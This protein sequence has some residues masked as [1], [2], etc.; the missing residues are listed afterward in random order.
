MYVVDR[1]QMVTKFVVMCY[2][3]SAAIPLLNW[4]VLLVLTISIFITRPTCSAC[5]TPL[6]VGR[7]G[8]Q[9][10]PRLRHAPRVL[11]PLRRAG[12]FKCINS[13]LGL[14]TTRGEGLLEGP[15][16]DE[17]SEVRVKLGVGGLVEGHLE[18]RREPGAGRARARARLPNLTL[19]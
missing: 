1:M 19:A 16:L 10:H 12:F 6:A 11:T 18:H 5:S 17:S 3:A 8:R 13:E 4:V 15:G 14:S 2:I 7:S 9:V